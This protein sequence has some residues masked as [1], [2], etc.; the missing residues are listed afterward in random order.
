M[1]KFSQGTNTYFISINCCTSE[2]KIKI[3]IDDFGY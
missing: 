1:L 3:Y 2:N